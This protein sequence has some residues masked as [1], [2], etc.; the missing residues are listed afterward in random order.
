MSHQ[1]AAIRAASL[2]VAAFMA[3][4]LPLA[5][6]AHSELETAVP[7]DGSTVEG[8]PPE[9]VL[10]FTEELNP[11]KSSIVL[12]DSHGTKLITAGVD[13]DHNNVMRLTPPN[14]QPGEYEID[15]TSVATD[16]DLLRGKVHF[17]VT[18]PS[19]SPTTV[20]SESAAPSEA[21]SP[22]VSASATPT[23]VASAAPSPTSSSGT[24]VILPV[25]AAIV[26]IAVLGAILL[27]GRAGG[28]AR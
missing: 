13:P 20:P 14:I 3:F 12:V 10:T 22:V 7:A 25:V 1:N 5:A 4:A 27:R 19:P 17:T 16:G 18:A 9:V 23:P 2:L 15:W 24:D 8:T 21:P 11:T 26:L 6:A 28:R